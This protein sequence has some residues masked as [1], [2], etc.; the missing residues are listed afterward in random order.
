MSKHVCGDECRSNGCKRSVRVLL[1]PTIGVLHGA[2]ESL[3]VTRYDYETLINLLIAENHYSVR[4]SCPCHG[5][6]WICAPCFVDEAYSVPSLDDERR[7]VA[8]LKHIFC[9]S[10]ETCKAATTFTLTW[11]DD[12]EKCSVC[13]YQVD[14]EEGES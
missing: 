2:G 1:S 3:G 10:P 14:N 12:A 5:D 11:P 13:G 4:V 6:G 7:Q 8:S 9:D